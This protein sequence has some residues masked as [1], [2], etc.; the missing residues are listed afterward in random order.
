MANQYREL[1]ARARQKFI[2]YEMAVEEP[3]PYEHRKLMDEIDS[4]LAKP[5]PSFEEAWAALG[6]NYGAD[7]LCC[8]RLGWD[9]RGDQ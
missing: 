7:A 9:L 8:V 6:Y 1:L 4:L 2:D 3:A 5:E